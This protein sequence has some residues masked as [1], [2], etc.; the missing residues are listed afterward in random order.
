[1]SAVELYVL[2]NYQGSGDGIRGPVK[3]GHYPVAGVLS[4]PSAVTHN[5]SPYEGI[6][7]LAEIFGIF[8]AQADA[9]AGGVDHVGKHDREGLDASGFRLSRGHGPNDDGSADSEQL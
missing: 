3:R 8:L 4:D 2:L 7:A 6:M 9:D 1:M 5:G